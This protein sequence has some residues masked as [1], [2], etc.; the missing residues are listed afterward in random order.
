MNS[1]GLFRRSSGVCSCPYR[2]SHPGWRRSSDGLPSRRDARS[3][4]TARRV[5]RRIVPIAGGPRSRD[6]IPP[7]AA[8]CAEAVRASQAQVAHNR[9]VDLGLALP[10]VP[11]TARS[12]DH[13][14][15]RNS[16]ALASGRLPPVLALEV[17]LSRRSACGPGRYPRSD[18][19]DEPRQPALGRHASME[20][21]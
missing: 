4:E 10:T 21:C 18:P 15:A 9:S 11:V 16:G 19:D 12:R 3:L 14:Q 6:G 7:P 17:A 8:A 1:D 20:S 13:L 5:P 2:K